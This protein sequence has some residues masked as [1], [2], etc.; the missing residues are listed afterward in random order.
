MEQGVKRVAETRLEA[1]QTQR[2]SQDMQTALQLLSM[3]LMDLSGYM[4]KAVQENPALEYVPPV[5]SPMDYAIQVRTRFRGGTED[6]PEDGAGEPASPVMMLDD[7]EQQ[8]RLSGFDAKTTYLAK[9]ML[10][11]LNGRGYFV[12]PLEEFAFD[13]GCSMEEARQAL[14]AVQSLEPPG[15]GAR[16]V[17]ECLKLQLEAR[18][19]V[20]PLCYD[21]VQ[22][23]LMD[24]AKGNYRQIARETGASAKHVQECVSVIRSLNPAPVSLSE[25]TVQYIMPE[26]S[27]E[28]DGSGALSIIFH[29]DYYPTIRQDENFRRLSQTLTGEEQEYARKM[30]QSSS[31]LI[32]AAELRQRTIEKVAQ[33]IVR[34][35]RPFFLGQYSLMPLRIDD[36]AEEIGVHETTVYRAVQNKYLFCTRGTFSLHYFFQRELSGG[37]STARVKELIREI[38]LSDGK[39]SDQKIADELSRRGIKM[40]RRTVAKYRLQMNIASGFERETAEKT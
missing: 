23:H 21:L 8:L 24:I 17:E 4:L 25:G 20:D 38:C 28:A 32:R 6:T 9:K 2:L 31:R 15:I 33:I 14:T 11:Q 10:R 27:I 37:T 7:L 18:E 26:F 19:Q 12:K 3:D 16:S 39:L 13:S 1:V 29:N 5:K 30:L 22:V 36:V 40:A 34:E 35:Q